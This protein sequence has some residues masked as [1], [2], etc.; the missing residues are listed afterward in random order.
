MDKLISYQLVQGSF[1]QQYQPPFS[2]TRLNM[3]QKCSPD[4]ILKSLL[5]RN[6]WILSWE[7]TNKGNKNRTK[8]R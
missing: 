4:A 5:L 1:H 6:E 7:T 3:R 2:L 8:P